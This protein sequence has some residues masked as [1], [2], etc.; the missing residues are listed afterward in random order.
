MNE[1]RH[2]TESAGARVIA[3]G[4]SQEDDV[5]QEGDGR[6]VGRPRVVVRSYFTDDSSAASSGRRFTGADVYVGGWRANHR[7]YTT[8]AGASRR[9]AREIEAARTERR[10]HYGTPA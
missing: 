6:T 3:A 4:L 10:G 5:R 9:A 8:V 1:N 7:R 2:W